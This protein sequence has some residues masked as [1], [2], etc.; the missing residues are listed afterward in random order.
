MFRTLLF[1]TMFSIILVIVVG[2]SF[3]IAKLI[4]PITTLT[5]VTS[6]ISKGNLDQPIT[7][8]SSDEIGVL[9]DGFDKMR[10]SIKEQLTRLNLEVFKRKFSR[11]GKIIST[12]LDIHSLLDDTIAILSRTIDKKILITKNLE[13]ENTNIIGDSSSLQNLCVNLGINASHAMADGGELHIESENV[14]MNREQCKASIFNLAVGEY[15]K[16]TFE[17][18][19]AGISPDSL[20]KIFDPYFT[21]KKQGKGSGLGLAAA[22]GTVRDHQGSITVESVMGEGSVFTIL[23]PCSNKQPVRPLDQVE[24]KRG[25]GTVLLVDDEEVIR[26]TGKQMLKEMGYTATR[27]IQGKKRCGLSAKEIPKLT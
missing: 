11:K 6:E 23:L 24:I 9:A 22:Y 8:T 25:T 7:V 12:A 3:I 13:A 19:G 16:I 17:D 4:H 1:V 18:N 5:G 15:I 2:L 21:T 10:N 27:P 20:T 14:W 26:V